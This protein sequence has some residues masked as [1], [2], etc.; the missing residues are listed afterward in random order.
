[1]INSDILNDSINFN[2]TN[3]INSNAFDKFNKISIYNDMCVFYNDRYAMHFCMKCLTVFSYVKISHINTIK[4]NAIGTKNGWVYIYNKLYKITNYSINNIKRSKNEWF[5]VDSKNN[6]YLLKSE[7]DFHHCT[8]ILYDNLKFIQI[9]NNYVYC[10]FLDKKVEKIKVSNIKE[11]K[12]LLKDDLENYKTF[13]FRSL[14]TDNY[15]Q[16]E[17]CEINNNNSDKDLITTNDKYLITNDIDN[18]KLEKSFDN[19]F[20]DN[21]KRFLFNKKKKTLLFYKSNIVIDTSIPFL[22]FT[23]F[24]K[25]N[26]SL[27]L[28]GTANG[29]LFLLSYDEEYKSY[30]AID[31]INVDGKIVNIVI[32]GIFENMTTFVVYSNGGKVFSMVLYKGKIFIKKVVVF[33]YRI[34]YGLFPLVLLS[35][36]SIIVQDS[37][38]NT[39]KTF[40][41][42]TYNTLIIKIKNDL[43]NY[44]GN[45]KKYKVDM[46]NY[47][48]YTKNYNADTNN[49]D[50][51]TKNYN[52]DTKNYKITSMSTICANKLEKN[53]KFKNKINEFNKKKHKIKENNMKYKY[54]IDYTKNDCDEYKRNLFKEYCASLF[55]ISSK[56]IYLIRLIDGLYRCYIWHD[57]F[58]W[59]NIF[60]GFL[61]N[62]FLFVAGDDHKILRINL[63]DKTTLSV[64]AH[65][66]QIPY[67]CCCNGSLYSLGLDM[68]VNIFDLNFK[69]IKSLKHH[70]NNAK[71][72]DVTKDYVIIYGESIQKIMLK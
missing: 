23:F 57:N 19:T 37:Y 21:S 50:A 4:H 27:L 22:D 16:Y 62:E 2:K 38:L 7:F 48:D 12:T 29:Y 51:N 72:M 71:M 42:T 55:V 24:L 35:N 70:V 15:I 26:S 49:Y 67:I 64:V 39:I 63:Y 43:K 14:M 31:N 40:N 52:T 41:T 3:Q 11:I 13:I 58:F 30:N 36:G 20:F 5:I 28:L 6:L 56:K 8:A 34:I 68:Q 45:L 33:N 46:K 47:E 32:L 66:A 59:K 65:T 61:K 60:S 17:K 9:K 54:E 53:F 10:S 1:M 25:I 44:D 69:R 18:F